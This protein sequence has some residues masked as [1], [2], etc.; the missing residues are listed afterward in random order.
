MSNKPAIILANPATFP[1]PF[2]WIP[3]IFFHN[4]VTTP[5]VTMMEIQNELRKR[6]PSIVSDDVMSNRIKNPLPATPW[7]IPIDTDVI[8]Q[9]DH[10]CIGFK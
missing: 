5:I 6:T 9:S 3:W 2:S 8:F 4:C 10:F 7:T 1:M